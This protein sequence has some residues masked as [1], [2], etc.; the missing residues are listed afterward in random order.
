MLIDKNPLLTQLLEDLMERLP[1]EIPQT[2]TGEE[3]EIL[4]HEYVKSVTQIAQIPELDIIRKKR[5]ITEP[6]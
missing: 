2:K 6:A 3:K 4:E 1:H 5:F